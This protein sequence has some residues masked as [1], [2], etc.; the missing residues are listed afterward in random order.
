MI[1]KKQ[2]ILVLRIILGG[3]FVYASTD[4][5]LHPAAFA[6]MIYNYQIV[7]DFLINLSALVLPWLEL[8][9]GVC[10]ISGKWMPGA[11]FLLN[12]LLIIFFAAL[13][14]NL[15]RGININCGCFSTSA[16]PS[17]TGDMLTDVIRDAVFLAMS[18]YLFIEVYIE[19]HRRPE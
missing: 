13:L 14:F 9:I 18:I 8:F 19:N 6:E 5:I 4:K 17:E 15:Y 2:S 12:V 7:P 10:L 3:I 1:T 11:A 16:T